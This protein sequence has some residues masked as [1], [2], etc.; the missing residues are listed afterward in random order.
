MRARIRL[1]MTMMMMVT[2]CSTLS[3]RG[4]M[5]VVRPEIPDGC[6]KVQDI[7]R[8]ISCLSRR[9]VGQVGT[10]SAVDGCRKT[11]EDE[12]R[13]QAG[14]LGANLIVVTSRALQPSGDYVAT[15]SSYRCAQFADPRLL[16]DAASEVRVVTDASAVSACR[17]VGE[18]ST[19]RGG[20][21]AS[22]RSQRVLEGLRE[23]TLDAGGNTLLR[24]NDERSGVAYLCAAGGAPPIPAHAEVSDEPPA[25]SLRQAGAGSDVRAAT[26]PV[27]TETKTG[28]GVAFGNGWE[29]STNFRF[30]G[31]RVP[32]HLG[33]TR[34]EPGVRAQRWDGALALQ[35]D[36]G[37]YH[38]ART[39]ST[40]LYGGVRGGILHAR[41][42]DVGETGVRIGPGLGAEHF[43]ADRWSLGF[44]AAFL[45][46]RVQGTNNIDLEGSLLLRA[47]WN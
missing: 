16:P 11:A 35:L 29:P 3:R 43:L 4:R 5:V 37:V 33:S 8:Q 23:E 10:T 12:L 19:G 7:E 17:R 22:E 14:D 20:K 28:V 9:E 42:N 41:A 34:L 1:L 30:A 31:L 27:R 26:A 6:Q 45:Y 39:G 24:P 21:T 38:Q 46:L 47:Y 44:E 18:V 32:I 25:Q 15:A 36:L 40:F 13:N 2:A